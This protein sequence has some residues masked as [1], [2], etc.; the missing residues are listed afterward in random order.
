MK[1]GSLKLQFGRAQACSCLAA[2]CLIVGVHVADHHAWVGDGLMIFGVFLFLTGFF[3]F[4][5][6]NTWMEK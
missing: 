3:L 1:I 6:K 4:G 5:K 2:A